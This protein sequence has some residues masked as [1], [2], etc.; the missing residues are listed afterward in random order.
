MLAWRGEQ[1]LQFPPRQK[2]PRSVPGTLRTSRPCDRADTV[3]GSGA[4]P[5]LWVGLGGWLPGVFVSYQGTQNPRQKVL[6][7]YFCF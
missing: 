5:G 4:P 2:E 7:L 1:G 6:N 3:T